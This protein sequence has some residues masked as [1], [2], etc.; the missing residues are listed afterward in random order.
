MSSSAWRNLR[1]PGLPHGWSS[2]FA[3]ACLPVLGFYPYKWLDVAQVFNMTGFPSAH[4][5][6]GCNSAAEGHNT[7]S[8]HHR[9]IARNSPSSVGGVPRLNSSDASQHSYLCS[10]FSHPLGSY[11][12][13]MTSLTNIILTI[14]KPLG[15]WMISQKVGLFLIWI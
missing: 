4:Q 6:G 7:E 15:W 2:A 1:R 5:P 13:F 12:E 9:G 11:P 10:R 14:S 3:D 8:Y